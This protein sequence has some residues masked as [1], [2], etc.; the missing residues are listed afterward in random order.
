MR[1]GGRLFQRPELQTRAV[2][3]S[4]V[5]LDSLAGEGRLVVTACSASQVSLETQARKHHGI[6][7]YHLVEGLRGAADADGD[8]RVTIDELYDYVY[9]HVEQQISE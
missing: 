8:G 6:F 5:F 9:P 3:L 4:D 7:T 1:A 2:Q